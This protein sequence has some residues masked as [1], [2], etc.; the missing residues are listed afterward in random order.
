MAQQIIKFDY[1]GSQIPFEK[2]S[3]VMVN[4]T[5][6]AKAYPD[7]NLSTIVN[8]QEISDYCTSLSKLQNFSF[9]DLLIVRRGGNNPGT[10]AHQKVA[11][12][13][14]QKLSP[15]FAV[16]VD[17][18]LEELLTT[19]VTTISND[20]E[21]ILQAMTV[22][23][24]RLD[25]SKQRVQMLEGQAE[26][27]Q[28][29]IRQLEP[30]AQYT[31]EVLQSTTTYTL[32]QIAHDLGMR[33]VHVFTDTLKK[34]GIIYRQSGQWQPTAKVA[35]KGIFETRTAK[36]IKSDNTIGTSISTVITEF[37]RAYLHQLIGRE[38]V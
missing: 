27:Q 14:A 10:W 8:S 28:E 38:S 7:K 33:S 5:A 2:G 17:T 30:K 26:I 19:G 22:L 16:W 9:A 13:V 4:L 31:D 11:L 32:T 24:K 18:R 1:N 34:K 21:V 25:D 29:Q 36:Y 35:G 15:D 12:R 6:M 3:D 20:D 37:G 23:Q